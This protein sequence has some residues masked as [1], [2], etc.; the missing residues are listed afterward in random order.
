MQDAENLRILMAMSHNQNTALSGNDGDSSVG[1][2][3][4]R[5][6]SITRARHQATYVAKATARR[7][8][9]T[10]PDLLGSRPHELHPPRRLSFVGHGDFR[11]TGLEYLDHFQKLAG[12]TPAD[13]VLD[14]GCGI[15]RMAIPLM[16]FLGDG[17]YAGFD[18]GR[19]MIGWCQRNITLQRPNFEFTWAPIYNRKYNPFGRVAGNEFRFPYPDSSF[20]FAFAISLFTHLLR[21]EVRHYLAET[22]RVLRPGG[23]CL[24]TFFLLTPEAEREIAAGRAAF[25]FRYG[26]DGGSTIDPHQ[27]EEAVAYRVEEVRTMLE[28]TGLYVSEPIFYGLWANAPEG[29]AGQDIVVASR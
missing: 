23:T 10:V 18:V 6:D 2:S 20:D 15:G 27:P 29:I 28:D 24:L 3:G 25:D 4:P 14:M 21:D 11:Q 22:A 1:S 9:W 7:I 12:L 19:E 16:P 8:R 13:R 26:I 5:P 17:S